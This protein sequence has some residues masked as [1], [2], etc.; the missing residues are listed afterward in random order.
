MPG[1]TTRE[2]GVL[3][4]CR[5]SR[6]QR[7]STGI[8]TEDYDVFCFVFSNTPLLYHSIIPKNTQITGITNP[9]WGFI[10]HSF[11]G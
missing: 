6:C 4:N 10:G 7:G 5:R 8:K 11:G 1:N 9:L 2:L 3:E